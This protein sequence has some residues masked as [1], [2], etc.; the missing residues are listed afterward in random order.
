VHWPVELVL[1]TCSRK[2][3]TRTELACNQSSSGWHFESHL[4]VALNFPLLHNILLRVGNLADTYIHTYIQNGISHSLCV[5]G[6]VVYSLVIS[7]E[8]IVIVKYWRRCAL[9]SLTLY[10]L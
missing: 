6:Y 10:I 7:R 5:S 9:G 2:V 1:Q 4:T 8:F 3:T